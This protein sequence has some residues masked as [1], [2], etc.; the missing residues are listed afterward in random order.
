MYKNVIQNRANY[1][2]CGYC[3]SM[4]DLKEI[5]MLVEESGKTKF[6]FYKRLCE[7]V[8]SSQV[9]KGVDSFVVVTDSEKK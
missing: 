6:Y 1:C 9:T 3:I 2:L 5:K 7:L 4:E 8:P